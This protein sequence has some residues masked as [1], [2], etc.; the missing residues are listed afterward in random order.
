[1]PLVAHAEARRFDVPAQAAAIGIPQFARQAGLQ[2]LVPEPLTRG[3]RT[4]AVAGMMET[5]A[6]LELLLGGTG[7]RVASRDGTVITL[8]AGDAGRFPADGA[9]REDAATVEAVVVTGTALQNQQAIATRRNSL[10]VV[11]AL[12]QDDTGDLA[13]QSLAEALSRVPAVSTMQVLYGEQESQYVAVRGI[14]PD[15]NYVSVD[16]I[17]MISVA[18][19]G[20]GQRRVD[21]ALIPS[22]AARK[23][24]IYKTFTA[25]QDAGAIGGVINIVPYS[26]FGLGRDKFYVDSFV[27]YVTD[28]DVPGGNSL[29]GYKDSSWSGGVK[30]LWTHRFGADEQF[31]VVL[32]GTYQQRSY[33]D[34]KRN[35]NARTYYTATG[36]AT[37]P[38]Q[39]NWNGFDPAPQAMV[40]YEFTSYIKTYGGSA[41]FEFKPTAA[42]Y[43]SL[44]L[45]DYKQT[46]DQTNN[47]FTLRGFTGLTNQ[48]QHTGTLKIPDVRT[49]FNYDRFENETRGAIFKTHYDFDEKT[50][51]EFRAGYNANTFYDLEYANAYQAK[52]TGLSIDYDMSGDSVGFSLAGAGDLTDA[53][54]YTLLTAND[55]LTRAKGEAT[56]ARLDFSRNFDSSSLGFGYKAG[57]GARQ[58]DVRRDLDQTIYTPSKASL[59]G[60]EY[61]PAGYIPWMW[62]YP[63][64][65][66]DYAK[67]RQDI[68]P[69]LATNKASSAS[70]SLASDYRYSETISYAY[71]SGLYA[72]EHTR[73][74][75]GLRL[76]VADYSADLPRSVGGV[77]QP[78]TARYDGDYKHLLPSLNAV[79]DFSENLRLKAGYSRTLGRPAPEDIAQAETRDDLNLT[80]SRG[81]PD[82]KPRRSDN[83]DLTLERYFSGDKGLAS[84]GAFYKTIKDDIYALKEEQLIDGV[85]YT[86]STPMNANKSKMRGIEAQYINNAIP[87]LPG[88]LK[89]KVGV[90]LNA[91]RTWGDMDYIVDG[92]ALHIDRLLYQR[93]WMANVAVFYKL[94][95]DGE[96]RLGYNWGDAYYD[97]IGASPWL[98]RGPEA[99]GQ[100]DATVRYR[101][102]GDW[103][104][105]LQAKNILSENLYLG[106]DDHLKERRAEMKKGPSFFLNIIY[107]P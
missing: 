55:T 73:F 38:D 79:H 36:A 75:A 3:V 59:S 4:R 64:L 26:A 90:A 32:S 24:E 50:N 102:A 42:W 80:I 97:G 47:V 82:L 95:R 96:A 40:D 43:S 49:A 88:P 58:F 1:M 51:L 12:T 93:D 85:L 45:Y 65:W 13:D 27:N 61:L 14:T 62:N 22:Q 105:K 48:T 101:V 78:G 71:L 33:D 70:A 91:T 56:E 8:D 28:N 106:Y 77:Y 5:R 84:V 83:L 21:L 87:G 103:I 104:V 68:L 98:N 34:V 31:G 69:G 52:P 92:K 67:F 99:R 30:S 29:G 60:Y 63:V 39:A 94:P 76:D 89:D 10:T 54:K 16:G 44:M 37:T 7:L 2:V 17:G 46:E 18:N 20:A 6:A 57:I 19:Q 100:M 15:L 41:T 86:V 23:T 11:D 81:N 74:I 25:D 35:P 107:R 66:I 9:P 53:K 72:M